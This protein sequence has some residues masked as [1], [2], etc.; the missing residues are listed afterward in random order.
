MIAY[1]RGLADYLNVLNAQTLLFRQR[2]IRAASAGGPLERACRTGDR[3]GGGV[4]PATTYRKDMGPSRANPA[5]LAVF[6]H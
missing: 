4:E 3:L 2:R 5:A 6:D 1:Q